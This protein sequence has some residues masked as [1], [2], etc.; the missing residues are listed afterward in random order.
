MLLPSFRLCLTLSRLPD[1]SPW[2]QILVNKTK[3]GGIFCKKNKVDLKG[4]NGKLKSSFKH[5][6]NAYCTNVFVMHFFKNNGLSVIWTLSKAL[7]KSWS[8][9][10]KDSLVYVNYSTRGWAKCK[11]HSVICIWNILIVRNGRFQFYKSRNCAHFWDRTEY[12][13]CPWNS[14]NISSCAEHSIVKCIKRWKL[15]DPFEYLKI[16]EQCQ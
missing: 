7:F 15:F 2:S 12:I 14:I 11:C 8:N 6:Q 1:A 10:G 13:N 9:S 4:G 16:P 5:C 3:N